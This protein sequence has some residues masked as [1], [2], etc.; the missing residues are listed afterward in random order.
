MHGIHQIQYRFEHELQNVLR[1][2]V[3]ANDNAVAKDCNIQRLYSH[4]R[5]LCDPAM[6]GLLDLLDVPNHLG[7]RPLLHPILSFGL[8]TW[9]A[10]VFCLAP[11]VD[12]TPVHTNSLGGNNSES[13]AV[14][15]YRRHGDA[16]IIAD[17]NFL[18]LVTR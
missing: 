2:H 8:K 10:T 6:D 15:L 18:S 5:S 11:I 14:P 9:C 12:F 17:H 7:L 16:D 3:P 13:H 1:A 4:V